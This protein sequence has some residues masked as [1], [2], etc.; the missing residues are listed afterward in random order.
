[1]TTKLK[2]FISVSNQL[3][4]NYYDRITNNRHVS[5]IQYIKHNILLYENSIIIIH[6]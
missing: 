1:M 2:I 4:K 3:T 5:I 6:E